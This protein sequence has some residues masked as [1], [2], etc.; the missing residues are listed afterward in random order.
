MSF[1][2]CTLVLETFFKKQYFWSSFNFLNTYSMVSTGAIPGSP[3]VEETTLLPIFQISPTKCTAVGVCRSTLSLLGSQIHVTV[4]RLKPEH[5]LSYSKKYETRVP[6]EE[7][8][9]IGNSG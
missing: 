2:V 4:T 7:C 8:R 6:V 5:S 9:V 1:L 3:V